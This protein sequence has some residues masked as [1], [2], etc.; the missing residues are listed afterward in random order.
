MPLGKG[1]TVEGQVTGAE[2]LVSPLPTT[3]TYAVIQ[4]VGG[5]QIDVFQKYKTNVAF[6]HSGRNV[7]MYKSARKLG[8]KV[9]ESVQMVPHTDR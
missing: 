9:G 6:T 5:I 8:L 7:N 1:Y 2:V 3:L 4:N